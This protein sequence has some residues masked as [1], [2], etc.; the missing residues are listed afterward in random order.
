MGPDETSEDNIKMRDEESEQVEID[1]ANRGRRKG[2]LFRG[3]FRNSTYQDVRAIRDS[4]DG[5]MRCPICNWELEDGCCSSCSL[6]FDQDGLYAEGMPL[7]SDFS[8]ADDDPMDEDSI[9]ALDFDLDAE[10]HALNEEEEE[11]VALHSAYHADDV[12]QGQGDGYPARQRHLPT[13]SIPSIPATSSGLE[14]DS[15]GDLGSLD[16]FI[17]QDEDE[18]E[19]GDESEEEEEDEGEGEGAE[20]DEIEASSDRHRASSDTG[21]ITTTST[22]IHQNT[23]SRWTPVPEHPSETLSSDDSENSDEGG[24]ISN[25]RRPRQANTSP[26]RRLRDTQDADSSAA[27][28]ADPTWD[29]EVEDAELL[30]SAW[31]G[32]GRG[33]PGQPDTVAP[34]HPHIAQDRTRAIPRNACE[35]PRSPRNPGRVVRTGRAASEAQRR[36][37]QRAVTILSDESESDENTSGHEGI[38]FDDD[39][40]CQMEGPGRDRGLGQNSLRESQRT[41]TA[42]SV[43]TN[44]DSS[45]DA[46]IRRPLRRRQ[47]RE[48]Q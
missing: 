9:E 32:F 3:C 28:S 27:P 18:D 46:P 7:D 25:G 12:I 8:D 36:T 4:E 6:R 30:R 14:S 1:K 48:H 29:R 13:P 15:E 37:R 20:D 2:G 31:S 24:A 35:V 38:G 23:R 11:N 34:R 10:L 22:F 16:D 39:G 21:V 43:Q 45:E 40:D 33:V 19:D 44:S 17:A 42:G 26:R 41:V 5:V 47:R